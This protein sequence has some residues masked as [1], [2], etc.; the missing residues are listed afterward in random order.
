MKSTV[1]HG[2][3]QS[4]SRKKFIEILNEVKKQGFDIVRV[5]WKKSQDADLRSLSMS[6]SLLSSGVC[7]AVENF[8]TGN[9]QAVDAMEKLDL[10]NTIFLFWEDKQLTPATVKKLQKWF[11]VQE[12]PIPQTIFNF[13]NSITP[14]NAK[15]ILNLFEEARKTNP[16][17][18]L[19]V[20]L[21]RHVRLLFWA[22]TE[23]Q[24]MTIP[25]WQ[26]ARFISQGKGFSEDQLLDLH[27]KLL[28]LDRKSKKS[29][30]PEDLGSSLEVLLTTL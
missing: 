3:N 26:K 21:A 17:E 23:S 27:A 28:D 18:M 14:N 20:M 2:E 29:Q 12:F 4:V 15:N 5:D 30:L 9:K 6:Q 25:D 22:K 1:L 19:L 16:D 7:I 8:F 24:T 13:L 10:K 11:L